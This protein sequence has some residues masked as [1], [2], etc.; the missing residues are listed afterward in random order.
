MRLSIAK[1]GFSNDFIDAGPGAQATV[2]QL[3]P[4]AFKGIGAIGRLKT[5]SY[6]HG[7]ATLATLARGLAGALQL[8]QSG[9]EPKQN[10]VDDSTDDAPY[11]KSDVNINR[12]KDAPCPLLD[13]S[14]KEAKDRGS[15][16]D[17]RNRFPIRP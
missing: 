11:I 14:A 4:I 3:L 10:N 6:E 15:G 12:W 1:L 16:N 13:E 17:Q 2:N 8:R 5:T 9:W 7:L